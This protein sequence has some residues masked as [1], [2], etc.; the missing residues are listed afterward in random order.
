[1]RTGRIGSGFGVTMSIVPS[2]TFTTLILKP[3]NILVRALQ[4]SFGSRALSTALETASGVSG[5]PSLYLTPLRSVKRQV[6]A[7]VCFHDVAS[8][9]LSELSLGS[10]SISVSLTFWRMTRPTAERALLQL[11][12]LSGSSGMTMVMVLCANA[13][14]GAISVIV[15]SAA[16]DTT[17]VPSW[18]NTIRNMAILLVLLARGWIQPA[19]LAEFY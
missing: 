16:I 4:S 8:R 13:A 14:P 15:I 12:R 19:V 3:E 18:R 9:G 17:A 6:V 5:V 11:S 7:S 2:S 1:M 10:S